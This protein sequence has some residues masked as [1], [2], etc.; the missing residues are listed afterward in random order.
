[1][2]NQKPTI[3]ISYAREDLETVEQIYNDFKKAGVNPWLDQEE[4]LPGDN[5]K[6][7]I[8]KAIKT[9]S[10]FLAVLSTNSVSKEGY[11]QREL[12]MALDLLEEK[13]PNKRFLIPVKID[14][15]QP[16]DDRLNDIHQADLCKNYDREF[17]LILKAILPEQI[18]KDI[19]Y[20]TMNQEKGEV[21]VTKQEKN[22]VI[23][24]QEEKV[25]SKI[26]NEQNKEEK[27]KENK[28]QK[29]KQKRYNLR[30]NPETLNDSKLKQLLDDNWRPK[31]YIENDYVD[32][33]DETITDRTTGLMWQKGGSDSFM[34]FDDAKTYINQLN[35][36]NFGGYNDWRLPTLEELI[37]L[38]ESEKM[39]NELYINP[40][41][42]SRQKWFWSSDT[43][44]S[45]GAFSVTF[46]S[47]RVYWILE[48]SSHYVRAVRSFPDNDG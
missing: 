29:I 10:Y 5:W 9:C 33:G 47:G 43:R 26:K 25:K 21:I 31:Q 4:I 35:K 45:S 36:S 48:F 19:I 40:M 1:M 2:A 17:R 13:P 34:E 39:G 8:K 44:A 18:K 27:P 7:K 14:E 23:V 42:D 22:E 6:L 28:K 30:S 20:K 24:K 37:S 15:C 46:S 32:N 3:F 41:F 16:L 12:K 11:V 38:L